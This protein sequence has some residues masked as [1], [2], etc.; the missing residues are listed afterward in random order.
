MPSP[1]EGLPIVLLLDKTLTFFFVSI[2][3]DLVI[4]VLGIECIAIAMGF[5]VEVKWG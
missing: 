1:G 5:L 2:V 3:S 4:D